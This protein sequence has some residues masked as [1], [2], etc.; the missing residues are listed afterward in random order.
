MELDGQC[1]DGLP[2]TSYNITLT[3]DGKIALTASL[4]RCEDALLVLLQS[5]KISDF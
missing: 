1:K 5:R 2:F 4:G 3:A